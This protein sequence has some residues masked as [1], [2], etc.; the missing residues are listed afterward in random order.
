[1]NVFI[2]QDPELSLDLEYFQIL[3]HQARIQ[4]KLSSDVIQAEAR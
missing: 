1:M 2:S 4:N 3:A